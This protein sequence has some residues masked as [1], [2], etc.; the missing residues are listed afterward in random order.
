[1]LDFSETHTVFILW[2]IMGSKALHKSSNSKKSRQSKIRRTTNVSNCRPIF[3][4]YTQRSMLQYNLLII[5]P[6]KWKLMKPLEQHLL[7]C[8]KCLTNYH[9]AFSYRSYNIMASLGVS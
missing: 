9:M 5:L 8:Q 2:Y 7:I 3:T 4:N 6:V 1:M